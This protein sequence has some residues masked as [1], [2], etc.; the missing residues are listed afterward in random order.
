MKFVYFYLCVCVWVWIFIVSVTEFTHAFYCV[1]QV[2]SCIVDWA[3]IC[4]VS[5]IGFGHAVC[6]W[7]LSLHMHCIDWVRKCIVSTIGFCTC[8]ALI[9][10]WN[11]VAFQQMIDNLYFFL[12]S[13]KVSLFV[14]CVERWISL[15]RHG[16]E[17]FDGFKD[18]VISDQINSSVPLIF[19]YYLYCYFIC[20]L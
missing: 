8:I 6:G 3:W 15:I 1:S 5:V 2:C 9:F 12:G 17:L 14:W 20:A 18:L 13:I 16:V 4:I 10:W 19:V 11:S 7:W